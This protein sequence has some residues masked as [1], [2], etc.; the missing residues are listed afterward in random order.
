MALGAAAVVGQVYQL[1]FFVTLMISMIGLAVGIDYSLIVVSRYREE[2]RRGREKLDA[3]ARTGAT[4]VLALAG[5]IIIPSNIFQAL[6]I[7]AILVVLAAVLASLTLLPAVLALLG[8]KVNALR[9]PFI[10]RRIDSPL[11]DAEDAGGGFWDW[12][13]R[14]VMRF[15]IISLVVV[16]GLMIAAAS[17]ALDLN[18]GFNGVDSMPDSVQAKQA[19]EVLEEKFSFGVV[20]PAEIV[21]NGAVDT[22][23]VQA[24][25]E[26]LQATLAEDGDFLAAQT[27][28]QTNEGKDLGL[29]AVPVAGEFSSDQ[30]VSAIRRLRD[31]YIP[32]AFSGIEAEALVTGFTAFNVDFFDMSDTFTPIIFAVVLAL[33]FVLLT[34][35]FRSIVVP[36]KAII[37]NL[38]SVGTAYGLMV[39]VF[40]EGVGADLLGFQQ[41]DI[42]DAWIPLFLFSVLFGLSMDYH[43]FL[44]SRVR[45]RYDQTKDNRLA[46]ASGLRSTASLITGAALIMVAV[47]GGFASGETV[48]NQQVGF[49]LAVAIF[50]DAT[51]VRSVLVPASMR[52]LGDFNWYFPAWLKW[53]PDLR[54]EAEGPEPAAASADQG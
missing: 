23:P 1:I 18:T 17:S 5:M 39:L 51:L 33:S 4:V 19:F 20:S 54:V 12:I 36:V 47:F 43:V 44:L 3:I 50:I 37:M 13:T 42:I 52:L 22:P 29:L 6:G 24:A 27:T 26:R 46:V 45:E 16:G 28:F 7:G 40:Q 34:V 35:A 11:S 38:L 53:L 31:D 10:G 15:P 49:G 25:I 9:V 8:D 32:S 21:I 2:R 48:S 30:A 14:T 41:S